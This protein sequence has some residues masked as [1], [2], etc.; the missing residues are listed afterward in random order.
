MVGLF[1]LAV[2]PVQ[3]LITVYVAGILA[4]TSRWS[5]VPPANLAA[6][7]G[8]GAGAGAAG[9][10]LAY[11]LTSPG[12]THLSPW[13]VVPVV[14]LGAPAAAGLAAAWRTSV[15]GGEPDGAAALRTARVQ[16]GTA[17]GAVTGAAAALLGNILAIGAMGHHP[18]SLLWLIFVVLGSLSGVAAGTVSGAVCADRPRNPRLDGSRSGGFFVFHS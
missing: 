14:G 15:P 1:V 17:A 6:G 18:G 12:A 5:P 11:A 8:A 9:A 3:L 4:V 16:Q 2:A 13:L 7:A 10:L